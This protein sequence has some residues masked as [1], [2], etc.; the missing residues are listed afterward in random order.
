MSQYD[1]NCLSPT[2]PPDSMKKSN[3]TGLESCGTMNIKLDQF[4]N[5]FFLKKK[6]K[7][8]LSVYREHEENQR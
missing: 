8:S 4:W 5:H 7:V 6:T 1:T 3:N 2:I